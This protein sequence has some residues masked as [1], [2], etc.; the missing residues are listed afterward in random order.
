M[1]QGCVRDQASWKGGASL[2]GAHYGPLCALSRVAPRRCLG[3]SLSIL[4]RSAGAQ[5]KAAPRQGGRKVMRVCKSWGR[6]QSQRK[7]GRW[8]GEVGCSLSRGLLRS[9]R[10]GRRG[11]V[12]DG[13]AAAK[14]APLHTERP[15]ARAQREEES[16]PTSRPVVRSSNIGHFWLA[17]RAQRERGVGCGE[18]C[19]LRPMPAA[20]L[21]AARRARARAR[22]ARRRHRAPP[23]RAYC[24]RC[25][26][27]CDWR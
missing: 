4:I 21:C 13:S 17:A 14:P 15:R 2:A 22:S 18:L 25:A 6:K 12:G 11:S 27:P 9:A 5:E 24:R 23:R 3:V 1:G 8:R 10:G 16:E 7:T 20:L 26:A 19:A